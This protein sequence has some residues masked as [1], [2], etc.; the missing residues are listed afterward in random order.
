VPAAGCEA[1]PSF[2]EL[3][4]P[5]SNPDRRGLCDV[6][7]AAYVHAPLLYRAG[8]FFTSPLVCPMLSAMFGKPRQLGTEAQVYDAAI[9]ILMRRAHSVH[10]MKK[11]L[12]RRCEDDKIVRGVVERL[13]RENLLDDARYAKQFTRRRTESRKQGEFRIARDLRARGIPDRH[14]ETAIKDAAAGT[15]PASIIRQRIERKLR[16][17]RGEIDERKLASLYRSLAGA[18][19]PSDLIRKELHR[20]T[21]EELPEIEPS[22]ETE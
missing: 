11:A 15:D 4:N 6:A 16:L 14:I 3:A 2:Q 7:H 1:K 20:I 17:Y 18:G 5:E 13:K 10:E 21:H 22:E 19:F 12:A 8:G 9:K